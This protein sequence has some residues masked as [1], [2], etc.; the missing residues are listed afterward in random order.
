MSGR[1][2]RTSRDYGLGGSYR[3]VPDIA[4][5]ADPYTVSSSSMKN[6]S[7]NVFISVVGG[8][9]LACRRS[10]VSGRSP[11]RLRH[12]R[13]SAKLLRFSMVCPPVPSR[14]LS[15]S[16]G[17]PTCP[18]TLARGGASSHRHLH[19]CGVVGGSLDTSDF[20][21]TLYDGTST[22]WYAL[23][24]GTDSSLNTAPGWDDV[25]GLGTPKQATF[26]NDVAASIP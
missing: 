22:R 26:V 25:T 20:I 1:Y 3:L 16:T 15:R 18:V 2:R 19:L 12:T 24:F 9:S 17:L 23:S 13:L 6:P 5:V 7:E 8:T 14:T 11:I 10:R 4:I 21:G